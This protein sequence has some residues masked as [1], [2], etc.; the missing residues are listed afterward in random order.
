MTR[1]L[2]L[3][4]ASDS[5]RLPGS[6]RRL[7]HNGL[8]E[9]TGIAADRIAALARR[10]A[11]TRP[12]MIVL[13]GSSMHKGAN[14]WQASRAIACLPGLT[15]NV[16]IP[17]AGFGPR[18]GGACHGRGL[19]NITAPER[20]KPGTA[21]PNQMSA[22]TAALRAGQIDN[23]LL[24]GTN[25]LSSFADSGALR[26]GLARTRMIVSYDLFLNDT[27]RQYADVVLPATAW[28]E[29]LG[30]KAT[31]THLYL[32]PR[33]LPPAGETRS[34]HDLVKVLAE[35]LKLEGFYPWSSEDEVVNAVLNHPCTGPATV[36]S[37][38]AQGGI[39]AMNVSHVANPK[40]EFDTPSGKIEFYSA[41]AELLGLSA[42]PDHDERSNDDQANGDPLPSGELHRLTPNRAPNLPLTL[43]QGRTLTHFHSFYNN[44]R[45]L[46]TLARRETEPH[47]WLSEPDAASR[48]IMH[49]ALVRMF[50]HQSSMT[51]RAHVTD[52]I[53]AGTLWMRDGWPG[54]NSLSEG[55]S[56]LPDSAVDKFGFAAG[57]ATY[58]TRVEVELAGAELAD[59]AMANVEF[60]DPD[61]A[62]SRTAT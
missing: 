42:L 55:Q 27:A 60:A 17:G 54:L 25:M 9:Q 29:E 52:R 16:G 21:M 3:G 39:A 56:V 53:E 50:N 32:M 26:E 51:A 41:Q 40:L 8:Q 58:A 62:E 35:R 23:L 34:L 19:G 15:G 12:A 20:R 24:M 22:I 48:K 28:L 6:W 31:N 57:Q 33:A 18:H 10:Y 1:I 2:S 61:S 14:G 4:I 44:G 59:V 37:L 36:A 46:P 43:A 47:L 7:P 45:E 38:S 49:G 5:T 30:C 13:G 11:S